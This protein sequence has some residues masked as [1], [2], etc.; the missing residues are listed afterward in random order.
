MKSQGEIIQNI[1][2]FKGE[3]NHDCD[4]E[5]GDVKKNRG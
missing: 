4:C 2:I 1:I 3:I 5:N